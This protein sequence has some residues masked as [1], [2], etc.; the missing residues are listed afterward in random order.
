[1]Q[2]QFFCCGLSSKFNISVKSGAKY[3]GNVTNFLSK[4]LK[5]PDKHI[6]D[7]IP[8]DVYKDKSRLS[9]TI[10]RIAKNTEGASGQIA[11][12]LKGGGGHAFNW[13]VKDGIVEYFDTHVRTASG[14]SISLSDASSHISKLSGI[15]GKI[16]RLDNINYEDLNLGYLSDM[17]NIT[18]R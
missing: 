3:E 12:D 17:F 4:A 14:S 7:T 16:T 5:N 11:S 10:L 8:A 6:Y 13:R 15:N 18:K 9:D 2:L 1:M